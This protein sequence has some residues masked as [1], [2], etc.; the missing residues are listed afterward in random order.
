MPQQVPDE[1]R[2]KFVSLD[3][4][5]ALKGLL[6]VFLLTD[7]HQVQH[8]ALAALAAEHSRRQ[9]I[10]HPIEFGRAFWRTL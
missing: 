6:Y 4:T 10:H 9:I 3:P 7:K 1:Y 5:G 2:L 8:V